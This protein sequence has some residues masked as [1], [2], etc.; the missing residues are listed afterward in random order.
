MAK[1]DLDNGII[2]FSESAR[3][4]ESKGR[5]R[6]AVVL[7]FKAIAEI[8]DLIILKKLGKNPD[9][10]DE[11]FNILDIHFPLIYSVLHRMFPLY[12]KTYRKS[13]TKEECE[14]AR[15]AFETIKSLKEKIEASL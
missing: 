9:N 6:S 15:N 12:R 11:R 3:D 2:E 8:S 14:N 1:F 4:E 5:F 7:Y 13:I 10:W